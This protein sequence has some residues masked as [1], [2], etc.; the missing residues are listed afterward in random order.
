MVFFLIFINQNLSFETSYRLV[1]SRRN[2]I[3]KYIMYVNVLETQ[4]TQLS[5]LVTSREPSLP[6]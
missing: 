5:L 3:F 6:N 4:L 2:Y 1:I